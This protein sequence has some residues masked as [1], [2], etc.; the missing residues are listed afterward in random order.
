[1]NR[2]SN[3]IIKIAKKEVLTKK[4]GQ[5]KVNKGL[6][7]FTLK[8]GL[9]VVLNKTNNSGIVHCGIMIGG[10]SRD[11]TTKNNGVA[12]FIEHTVFKGTKKRKS[13]GILNRLESVGGDLNAYTTREKT[14]FY[15]AVLKPYFERS[16]ELLSD[17]VFNPTFP[18]DGIKKEKSVIQEEI[19]MYL[20]SPEESIYDEF[21]KNLFP[22]HPLGFSIL[23]TN[24]S[25]KAIDR[26]AIIDFR[27]AVYVPENIVLS[28]S[29]NISLE[30]LKKISEK[31]LEDIPSANQ[32]LKRNK[33]EIAN[34]FKLEIQKDFQQVHCLI[35]G[36]AYSLE[37]K[38]RFRLALI[39]NI[40]GGDWM[41]SRLNLSIRE[42]HAYAYNINSHYTIYSDSGL[43]IVQ[44]G[45][46][47]KYLLKCM[48][49]IHKE[50]RKFREKKLSTFEL[51]RA[52]R[53][54][55]SHYS[56]LNES[57]SFIMQSIARGI[58]DF[59]RVITLDEVFR[60]IEKVSASDVLETAHEILNQHNLSTFVFKSK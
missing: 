18:D 38:K 11:E 6:H 10:G 36:P 28:V 16:V 45:T 19:E 53:Q 21:Q 4:N 30:K 43:Y 17:I 55:F 32:P 1:L 58:L 26:S 39:N 12:H 41:S 49:L 35:G 5:L 13:Y 24:D 15:S 54:I 14:C 8:N 2:S 22:G 57:N 59:G 25:L 40:L 50:F 56:M 46:D 20:D 47:Q 34:P 51:N 7:L 9:R 44:L 29:G 42:K 31:Y 52:K 27:K 23:G 48:D 33:P 60:E 37:D 3:Y